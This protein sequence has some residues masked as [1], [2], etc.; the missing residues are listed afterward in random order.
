VFQYHLGKAAYAFRLCVFSRRLV[1]RVGSWSWSSSSSVSEHSNFAAGGAEFTLAARR[2][3][4]AELLNKCS[5][6][7][8]MNSALIL[9]IVIISRTSGLTGVRSVLSTSLFFLCGTTPWGEVPLFL[10]FVVWGENRRVYI[11]YI[12]ILCAHVPHFRSRGIY[13]RCLGAGLSIY[14]PIR[15]HAKT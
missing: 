2:V 8:S 3:K 12:C 5:C 13:P 1:Q 11:F 14:I 4:N 7:F 10:F 15:T 6:A 9:R